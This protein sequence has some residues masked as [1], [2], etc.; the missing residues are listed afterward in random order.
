MG[1]KKQNPLL[2]QYEALWERR[3]QSRLHESIRLGEDAMLIAADEVFGE[4]SEEQAME[5]WRV[6][7]DTLREIAKMVVD[8]SK[9]DP[10][11]EWSRAKVDDRIR[12][13]VGEANFLPWDERHK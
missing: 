2:A 7:C 3:Y 13:I 8:D 6:Y 10:D 4:I 5:L 1:G 12:R 9:D 11:T